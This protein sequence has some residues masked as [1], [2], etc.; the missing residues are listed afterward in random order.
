MAG[1]A[2][3]EW[4][5]GYQHAHNDLN[6]ED[7]RSRDRMW[8]QTRYA[9]EF[10]QRHLPFT[11]MT[12]GDALTGSARDYCFAA[13][14]RVYAIYLPGGETTDL[15]LGSGGGRYTVRWYNPRQGGELQTG[16]VTTVQGPGRQQVGRPPSE[17][18]KDWVAL[19]TTR[20]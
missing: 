2:G 13:P 16:S 12:P 17:S 3:C 11:E 9:V 8:D 19:V 1:G 15:D 20:A 10:F 14:G 4:Y 18:E 6:C 7:W 5:F